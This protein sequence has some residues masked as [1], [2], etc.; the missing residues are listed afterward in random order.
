M[1]E[2]LGVHVWALSVPS[3]GGHITPKAPFPHF[4]GKR[5]EKSCLPISHVGSAKDWLS[6]AGPGAENTKIVVQPL[7]GPFPEEL[8]VM[9]L[10][11]LPPQDVILGFRRAI[12]GAALGPQD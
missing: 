7:P 4:P 2:G 12:L 1:A 9:V 5:L 8:D 3:S 11:V 6:W 10:R